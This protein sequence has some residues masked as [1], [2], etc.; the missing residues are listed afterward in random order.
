MEGA[1]TS[2]VGVCPCRLGG[3]YGPFNE[4]PHPDFLAVFR[5]TGEEPCLTTRQ[6][7]RA[8]RAMDQH[9]DFARF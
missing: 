6:I 4:G 3:P 8:P 9:R 1:F 5:V 2:P 7:R